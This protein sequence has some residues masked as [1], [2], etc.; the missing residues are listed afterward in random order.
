MRDDEIGLYFR[1]D[2]QQFIVRS[3]RIYLDI[4]S[5]EIAASLREKIF[6]VIRYQYIFHS[7]FRSFP[8]YG[9]V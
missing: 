7:R 1:V 4:R 8:L 3:R 9:I 2:T 6:Q 5:V